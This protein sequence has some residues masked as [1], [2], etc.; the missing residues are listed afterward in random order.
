[1]IGPKPLTPNLKVAQPTSAIVRVMICRL[2]SLLRGSS[3]LIAR[4]EKTAWEAEKTLHGWM[5]AEH[6]D[7]LP[8]AALLVWP[9]VIF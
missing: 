2:A 5:F 1:M 4:A 6:A 3:A 7:E 9:Y 8:L